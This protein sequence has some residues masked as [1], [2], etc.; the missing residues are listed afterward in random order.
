M[1]YRLGFLLLLIW[2]VV[3]TL[4]LVSLCAHLMVKGCFKNWL[5]V[6]V[7]LPAAALQERALAAPA[8]WAPLAALLV[9]DHARRIP[10]ATYAAWLQVPILLGVYDVRQCILGL[11]SA[12]WRAWWM[13]RL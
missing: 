8:A 13:Q 10:D 5:G 2:V 9:R 4:V 12:P 1:L 11:I 7:A 6:Q 3:K